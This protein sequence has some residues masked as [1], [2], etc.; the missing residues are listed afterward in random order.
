VIIWITTAIADTI[1]SRMIREE[2]R[3][4]REERRA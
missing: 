3:D 1:A 4:K 2:R